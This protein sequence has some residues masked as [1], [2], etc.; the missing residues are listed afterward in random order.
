MLLRQLCYGPS[1]RCFLM[2]MCKNSPSVV[3]LKTWSK[4]QITWELVQNGKYWLPLQTYWIRNAGRVQQSV[5]ASPPGMLWLSA[6]WEPCC[7]VYL[8][9][10]FLSSCSSLLYKLNLFSKVIMLIYTSPAMYESLSFSIPLPT[11]SF[12]SLLTL[13]ILVDMK[14]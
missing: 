9:E 4:H 6:V 14:W 13:A 5:V 12:I 10:T 1:C 2:H 3:V 8:E 7:R 11:L